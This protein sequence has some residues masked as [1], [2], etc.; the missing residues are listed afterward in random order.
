[1]TDN[2]SVYHVLF[3][4]TPV[5]GESPGLTGTSV[6]NAWDEDEDVDSQFDKDDD[7]Q[8]D[9]EEYSDDKEF[10]DDRE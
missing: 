3:A 1:M 6:L 8:E 9:E 10:D 7:E 2:R 5:K 4:E